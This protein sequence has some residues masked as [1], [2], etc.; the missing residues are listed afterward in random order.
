MLGSLRRLKQIRAP[1]SHLRLILQGSVSS[2][3]DE[4]DEVAWRRVLRNDKIGQ[5]RL[6]APALESQ[7]LTIHPLCPSTSPLKNE[8]YM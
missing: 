3:D 1:Q 2:Y 7:S 8:A 6:L 5:Q 4:L